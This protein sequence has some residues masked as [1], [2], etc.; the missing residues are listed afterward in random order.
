MKAKKT[1]TAQAR[2]AGVTTSLTAPF[3]RDK[4]GEEVSN[5]CCLINIQQP[6]EEPITLP[7]TVSVYN[8]TFIC[9]FGREAVQMHLESYILK[10]EVQLLVMSVRS[11][12]WWLRVF[13]LE[14]AALKWNKTGFVLFQLSEKNSGV[15]RAEAFNCYENPST[16]PKFKT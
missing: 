6:P 3:I 5:L 14:S 4:Q 15:W 13:T 8:K 9:A 7:V 12:Y 2:K 10:H 11:R 16:F 1:Q